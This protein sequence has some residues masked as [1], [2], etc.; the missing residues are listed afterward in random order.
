MLLVGRG[1]SGKGGLV[2]IQA[3]ESSKLTGGDVVMVSKLQ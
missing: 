2:N 3:G 1:N